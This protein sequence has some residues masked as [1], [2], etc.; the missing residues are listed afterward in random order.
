MTIAR[1]TGGHPFALSVYAT[2]AA[3]TGLVAFTATAGVV[4][5]MPVAT[6]VGLAAA[7]A[8]A[9]WSATRAA[10][11]A[12]LSAVPS[13]YRLAFAAGA[14]AVLVQLGFLTAFI[15]DPSA[16]RWTSGLARPWQSGHS[17]VSAYWVAAEKATAVPDIYVD[18]VYRPVTLGD[19]RRQPNLGPFIVDVFEYPPTFLPLPRLLAAA[20]PDFWGFRRLWF[21]INLAGVAIGLIVIARRIDA[22]L[23][24]HAVW[25]TP[26]ALAAPSVIGT[27]QVG[28][29]QLLFLVGSA[30]AML[31][32]ERRRP[33][34]G[35][36]L[37]GYA[38]VSK[39]YPGVLVFYL[40][41]RRDWR[42]VGWT[43]AAG[44]ALTLVALVDVGWTPM[45]AFVDHLPKIL[46]GEAFPGLFRGPA[47]AINESV[48][49][50][51]F[52]LGI[53]GVPGTGFAA[54]QVVG[55]LYTVVLVAMTAWFARRWRDH[56]LDPLAWI[57]ILTLATLRSPFLPGYGAF[58]ALW[59]ATL[60]MAVACDRPRPGLA[61]AA[62]WLVLALQF[63]QTGASPP[64]NA[65]VTF[66]H[67]LA[68]LLMVCAVLPRLAAAR[69]PARMPVR[70]AT[71]PG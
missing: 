39:L 21:A 47:I 56:R 33:A 62:L 50:I 67:T 61:A 54:A 24:T 42:A 63:G 18:T 13:T 68:S 48:P 12:H 8:A 22:S 59:L 29:V 35:G 27:L 17:C 1:P 44:V 31:L 34:V 60:V 10:L 16:Q 53:F 9:W 26:W 2:I 40:L 36:L 11:A 6:I 51:V 46:S 28:N 70:A 4:D 55:W 23:G 45:L 14:L 25:L 69:E 65:V 37:L 49:G 30:V 71:V 5:S 41:L 20:T 32:F 43:A 15:I 19:A 57:A 66:T 3:L 52:K 64:V 7:A 58:P 38:I